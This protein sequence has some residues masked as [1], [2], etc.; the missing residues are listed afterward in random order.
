MGEEFL[1][2]VFEAMYGEHSRIN[3]SS[4]ITKKENIVVLVCITALPHVNAR[5]I[6][7]AIANKQNKK[8]KQ[9]NKQC[10]P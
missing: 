7:N 6:S 9:T 10:N 5:Y 8:N 1:A 4:L 2:W 3:A